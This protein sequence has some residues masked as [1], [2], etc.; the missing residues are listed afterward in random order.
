MHLTSRSGET[1]R[2]TTPQAPRRTNSRISLSSGSETISTTRNLG[3]ICSRLEMLSAGSSEIPDS[4]SSTSGRCLAT[5]VVVCSWVSVCARTRMSSSTAKIFRMPTRK[6][7]S[8]SAMMTRTRV[9]ES[10]G[11]CGTLFLLFD[12][13]LGHRSFPRGNR[14]RSLAQEA[15]LVNHCC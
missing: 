2:G 4:I 11:G 9:G 7:G 5:A 12:R 1:E 8:L 3:A 15:V 10:V 14:L 6:M 13:L